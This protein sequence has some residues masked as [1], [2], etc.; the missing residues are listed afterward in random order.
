MPSTRA[1]RRAAASI[2][3]NRFCY[4][5]RLDSWRQTAAIRAAAPGGLPMASPTSPR[6]LASS[7]RAVAGCKSPALPL[8]DRYRNA[9]DLHLGHAEVIATGEV[10][11]LPVVA[12]KGDVGRRRRAVDNAAEFPAGLVHNP[13]ATGA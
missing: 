11:R 3:A 4:P 10:E 6:K 9:G 12:A 5:W 8:P 7:G 1:W 13:N 2:R